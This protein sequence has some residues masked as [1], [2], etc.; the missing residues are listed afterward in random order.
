M[1]KHDSFSL[2]PLFL[3]YNILWKRWKV[4]HRMDPSIVTKK[5]FTGLYGLSWRGI[6]F[7]TISCFEEN[8]I[9]DGEVDE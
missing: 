3:Y 5:K 4:S 2:R 8:F 1:E 6:R 7:R 9:T